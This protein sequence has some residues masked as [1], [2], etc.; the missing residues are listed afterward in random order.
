MSKRVFPATQQQGTGR[1]EKYE[2]EMVRSKEPVERE[3][4]RRVP[5]K[6]MVEGVEQKGVPRYS[7]VGNREERVR[8]SPLLSSRGL[9]DERKS[10]F[11]VTMYKHHDVI[12]ERISVRFGC[13]TSR[14]FVQV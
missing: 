11:G 8:R 7:A 3:L 5:A 2:K 10:K 13:R 6:T 9:V 14:K 1:R 12:L 4:T